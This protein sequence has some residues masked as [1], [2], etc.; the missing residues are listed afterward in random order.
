[1]IL[2]CPSFSCRGISCNIQ[3]E[4]PGNHLCILCRI[5]NR[6]EGGFLLEFFNLVPRMGFEPMISR[7]KTWRPRPD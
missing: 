4:V 1:M 7:M 2:W 3:K 5:K 6:R